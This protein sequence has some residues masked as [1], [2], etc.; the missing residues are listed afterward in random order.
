MS[1]IKKLAV[2]S[3]QLTNNSPKPYRLSKNSDMLRK[4]QRY[5]EEDCLKRV[6][7]VLGRD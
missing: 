3:N 4:L 1:N 7:S 5:F 2:M 6:N